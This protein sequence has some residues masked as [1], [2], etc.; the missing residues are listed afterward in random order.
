MEEKNITESK[1]KKVGFWKWAI[2]SII[3]RL[4]LSYFSESLNLSTRP[5]LSTPV[6]SLRRLAEGYWL[7]K[8]SVSPY[9]G[10][11][12]HGSPLLLSFLGPLIG[13][14]IRGQPQH[15]LCS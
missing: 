7:K 9:S 8:L 6:I 3:F 10:S 2:A 4:I 15:L 5:E 12:Y 11:M 1:I 14:K 13:K